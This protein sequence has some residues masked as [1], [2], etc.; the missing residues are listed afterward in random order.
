MASSLTSPALRFAANEM[1]T[2]LHKDVVKVSQ[3]TTNF[4]ADAAQKGSTLLI[5]VIVDGTA[6]E[7]NRTSNNYGD[8]DGHIRYTPIKFDKH[9]KHSFGFSENDFNLVNGTSFWAKSGISTADA[10]GRKIASIV[11]KLINKDN[12]KTS[13]VDETEFTD[14]N[15]DKV[16]GTKLS[17]SSANEHVIG[18]GDLTKKTVAG[19]RKACKDADI[20]VGQTILALNSTKFAEL[21]AILDANMYGGTEAIRSGI[22]PFLYGYKAVME[23]DELDDTNLVGALI[24]ETAVAVAGRIPEIQNPQLY[25]EVGTVTD[26][27]SELTVQFRRGGDWKTG[28]SVATGE[29]LF[30][31]SLVQPTKIVRLVTAATGSGS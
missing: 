6:G 25:T 27:K 19:F 11:G 20:P 26:E 22:I 5:P 13:G 15:G 12:V 21:L 23:M 9:I 1:I 14:V 3:F 31:A 4:T 10:I 24:P 7:F 29:S 16:E 8:V 2:A 28:D 30:G 17:F 18:T